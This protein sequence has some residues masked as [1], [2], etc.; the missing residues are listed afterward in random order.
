MYACVH[1]IHAPGCAGAFY[2]R[3][4]SQMQLKNNIHEPFHHNCSLSVWPFGTR[5]PGTSFLSSPLSFNPLNPKPYQLYR[6]NNRQIIPLSHGHS[7]YILYFRNRSP[8]PTFHFHVPLA[9]ICLMFLFSVLGHVYIFGWLVVNYLL[10]KE[11]GKILSK[12]E[13]AAGC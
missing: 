11:G 12:Y 1:L 4:I 3:K 5:I 7:N 6:K 10:T 2:P 13:E 8:K 9:F